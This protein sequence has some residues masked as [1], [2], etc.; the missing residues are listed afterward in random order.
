MNP[1]ANLMDSVNRA[2]EIQ[3]LTEMTR[4]ASGATWEQVHAEQLR[5]IL[6]EHLAPQ[7]AAEA[8]LQDAHAGRWPSV[9]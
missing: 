3:R 4:S 7:A 1:W 5:R 8:V 9:S 2:L 6:E